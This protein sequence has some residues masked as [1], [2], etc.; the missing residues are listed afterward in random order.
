MARTI[1]PVKCKFGG[2]VDPELQKAT[3]EKHK[4]TSNAKFSKGLE[5]AFRKFGIRT[6]RVLRPEVVGELYMKEKMSTFQTEETFICNR[7]YQSRCA[8]SQTVNDAFLNLASNKDFYIKN[9]E[10]ERTTEF[11]KKKKRNYMSMLREDG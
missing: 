1:D 8:A 11:V 7:I 5:R 10:R 3:T 6:K 4:Y 9:I 2:Y